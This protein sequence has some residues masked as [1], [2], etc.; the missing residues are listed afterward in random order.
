[1]T[2]VFERRDH[3]AASGVYRREVGAVLNRSYSG[4]CTDVFERRDHAAASGVY[5]C[6]V[7]AVRNRRC[8]VRA[9][10]WLKGEITPL[11]AAST[12]VM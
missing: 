4:A 10:M 11:R 6:D 2:D 9:R 5:R 1:C 12:G 3:A 8:S 7:A